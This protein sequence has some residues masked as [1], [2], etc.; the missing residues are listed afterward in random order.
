MSLDVSIVIVTYKCREAARDCLASIYETT[1]GV[2]FE[3]IVLDN[4]S[5]DGT[6]E[7]VRSDFP[8]VRVIAS[9]ENLGFA[10]GC[11]AAAAEAGGDFVFLL[12]PD[13]VLHDGTVAHLVEFARSR[14]ENGVYGGRTLRPDG[15]L[16]PGSCWAAPSLWSLV[17]FATL[18]T[19]AFRGSRFFDPEAM[20]GWK[21][22]S[23]REVDIVTGCLLFVTR[24]RW[25]ELGGFDL[26]FFMYGEDADFSLRARGMGLRPIVTPDA[27]VTHEVGVS[28]KAQAD[29]LI[30]LSSGKA[31]LL[32]KH[33][34]GLRLRA[35]LFLLAAGA[36]LRAL[37]GFGR[38]R[39]GGSGSAW[40]DVW[41][42]RR[43]WLA[44][45]PESPEGRPRSPAPH[46]TT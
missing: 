7:M 42:E 37:L 34:H 2:D 5:E 35:G 8:D 31:T 16:D 32:R 38:G 18:L 17:C 33:W 10:A 12:N 14:P 20:G 26:R 4:A 9:P 43:R 29:K 44:G 21:R 28:S 6:V 23:V 39:W 46:A 40:R 13:T 11:N 30:L 45:Y 41:R 22:D 19:T 36:G 3:V 24:S 25:E 1:S 15:E 27:V